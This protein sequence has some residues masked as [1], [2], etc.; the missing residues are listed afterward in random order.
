MIAFLPSYSERR[1]TCT[2]CTMTSSASTPSSRP[3]S[4]SGWSTTLTRSISPQFTEVSKTTKQLFHSHFFTLLIRSVCVKG[5]LDKVEKIF[6]SYLISFC[7]RIHF[8][9]LCSNNKCRW[10]RKFVFYIFCTFP[11]LAGNIIKPCESSTVP[12]VGFD[13]PARLFEGSDESPGQSLWTLVMTNPDGHFVQEDKEYLHWMVS[14]LDRRFEDFNVLLV[15]SILYLYCR[16]AT[17]AATIS[18]AARRSSTT[19][20]PSLHSARD[21]TD[22]SFY[23]LSR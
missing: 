5:K 3:A 7:C 10:R 17:S 12:S 21:T 18:P 2:A 11:F 19:C 14:C 20:S 23:S 8:N 6:L 4:I 15:D 22:T 16:L 1:P 9:N 13:L